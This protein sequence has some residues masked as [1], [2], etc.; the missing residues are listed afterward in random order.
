M[1]AVNSYGIS[2]SGF[3][4]FRFRYRRVDTKFYGSEIAVWVEIVAAQN[5]S[6]EITNATGV[7][8]RGAVAGNLTNSFYEAV[9]GLP[10]FLW[11][12]RQ[13]STPLKTFVSVDESTPYWA[14]FLLLLLIAPWYGW[15]QMWNDQACSCS[16][17]NVALFWYCSK[18]VASWFFLLYSH[19]RAFV[20][21]I[22]LLG[23]WIL[24]LGVKDV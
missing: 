1:Q 6:N 4:A 13:I 2:C 19:K 22:G 15:P 3:P 10:F 9:K 18:L 8:H 23:V 12:H 14:P 16:T 24:G 21:C 11:V 17:F 5:R 20:N 7:T